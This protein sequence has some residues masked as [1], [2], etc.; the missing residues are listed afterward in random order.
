MFLSRTHTSECSWL[1]LPNQPDKTHVNGTLYCWNWDLEMPHWIHEHA[2]ACLDFDNQDCLCPRLKVDPEVAG[3]R[4][5]SLPF[6]C[7]QQ[8]LLVL[9]S[10]SIFLWVI[11][12]F[13]ITALLFTRTNGPISPGGTRPPPS[14]RSCPPTLNKIDRV[15]RQYIDRPFVPFLHP[16][17]VN[18][19]AIFACA[20]DLAV[21]LSDTQLITGLAVLVDTLVSVP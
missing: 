21:S 16:L 20:A 7:L 9:T 11:P 8:V 15:S 1:N 2:Y 19:T 10:F 14:S 6:M 13:I 12:A 5:K 17:D 3:D 4:C 18:F